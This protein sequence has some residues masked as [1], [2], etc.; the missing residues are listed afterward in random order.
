MT[1]HRRNAIIFEERG[2]ILITIGISAVLLCAAAALAFSVRKSKGNPDSIFKKELFRVKSL[3]VFPVISLVYFF[4]A[5]AFIATGLLVA[6]K[7][8]GYGRYIPEN[9]IL[10]KMI[11]ENF[12]CELL[13]HQIEYPLVAID[14]NKQIGEKARPRI[15]VVGDSFVFG[16]GL[17]NTNQIWW[18]KMESELGRRG[19]D[20]EVYAAGLAGASTYDEYL[21]LKDT[22]L[23][24]DIQPDL[25]IIGYVVNDPDLGNL[26]W[27][28]K[29]N[30]PLAI[31]SIYTGH[32]LPSPYPGLLYLLSALLDG[33]LG[34]TENRFNNSEYGYTFNAWLRALLQNEN[35]ER[36]YSQVLQPLSKLVR[37]K[38]I[39]LILYPTPETPDENYF[40]LFHTPVL[41]LFEQ[42]GIP[43]YNPLDSFIEQYPNYKG[44]HKDREHFMASP[45]DPHPGPAST[46]FLGQY[47]VDVLEQN[48]PSI[49]G[50]KAVRDKSKL[51]IE[52]NDWM[53]FMLKPQAIQESGLTSQYTIQYPYPSQSTEVN[54]DNWQYGDFNWQHGNFLT[55]SMTHKVGKHVKLNFKTPVK[56]SSIKIEG[57]DLLSA[58]LYTLAINEE[59]GFDD[60]KP[61]NLGKRK[62]S[63]CAWEDG[64]GRYVTSLLLNAKTVD[65]KQ[66]PLTITI[67][68]DG[69]EEAFF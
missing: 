19:Y 29:F 1:A 69:S 4:Y 2:D 44:A 27:G 48:Y 28:I 13:S 14:A 62:G 41:P 36:Y 68:S 43:V 31:R 65:G 38:G 59:L 12:Y 15:L 57:D 25:I 11:N 21:W 16:E 32:N 6:E 50:Q 39:P 58:Q 8:S 3:R 33:K 35:L 64:S 24:E 66:A 46:T 22:K 54:W 9:Q 45:V 49:L 7:V 61:V 67:N 30:M 10:T 60:Q 53:P 20:C 42:A 26:G 18:R 17:S 63:Q 51:T 34:L 52:I 55:Y 5:L 23:L 47:A 56:L 40:K 37:E